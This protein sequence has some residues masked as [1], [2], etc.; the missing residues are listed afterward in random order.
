M[1]GQMMTDFLFFVNMYKDWW[2]KLYYES[3]QH[4]IIET[5][6]LMFIV[7]LMFIRKTVDPTRESKNNKLTEKEIQWLV[8]TWTPEPLVPPLDE[9]SEA[10]C[11]SAVVSCRW[12]IIFKNK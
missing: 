11:N 2:M 8:D 5:G 10:I 1:G 4:I 6:L 3:P 12:W 9:R 7:W